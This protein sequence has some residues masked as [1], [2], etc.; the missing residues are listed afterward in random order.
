[1]G[2]QSPAYFEVK[3]AS[4]TYPVVV[5]AGVL[6]R[7]P[8]E[9]AA[10]GL[11][12]RLWLVADDAVYARYGAS[13]EAVLR[14]AGRDVRSQTIPPGEESK[15]L[16]QA[17]V[18]YDWL[19]AERVERRDAILALGGGVVGDLAGFPAGTILCGLRV[20]HNPPTP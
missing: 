3:T 17:A 4:R 11:Q 14:A 10:A 8:Q 15:T 19:L 5:G 12:G 6:A 9:L 13:L 20:R 16:G 2:I 7:L 18:L 1:M